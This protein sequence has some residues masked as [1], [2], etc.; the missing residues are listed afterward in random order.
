MVK[1][2][3][4]HKPTVLVVD[5]DQNIISAFEDFFRREYCTMVSASTLEDAL[6]IIDNHEPD[7]LITDIR[8]KDRSGVSLLLQ[9]KAGHKDVPVIVITGYPELLTEK[10]VL[11]LGADIL[12]LKPLELNK[13]R[14]AVRSCLHLYDA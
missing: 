4:T 9:F 14:D 11:A 5:D 3:L 2:I 1:E 8:L 13:L 7:L 10:E 6:K 12:L